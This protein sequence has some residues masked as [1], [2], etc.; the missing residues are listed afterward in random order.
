[1]LALLALGLA[2][3]GC[4]SSAD[5]DRADR[6]GDGDD[7]PS[8]ESLPADLNEL[9]TVA[10]DLAT[11]V[12]GSSARTTV[13]VMVWSDAHR[14]GECDVEG[15]SAV[16]AT[17]RFDATNFPDFEQLLT[18]GLAPPLPEGD[19][20]DEGVVSL[21]PEQ[22]E[23]YLAVLPELDAVQAI[24]SRWVDEEVAPLRSSGEGQRLADGA[25]SCTRERG[26]QEAA[27]VDDFESLL[28]MGVGLESE[29]SDQR[30]LELAEVFVTCT[31]P[32]YDWQ[33]DVLLER[34][35]Q[36]QADHAETLAALS[37]ALADAGYTP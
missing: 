33:R 3:A 22:E 5:L 31:R 37:A 2:I 26:G 20:L 23:C 12:D 30:D 8:A 14:R 19:G 13:E 28:G 11:P 35:P 29:E 1:M 10:L 4:S 36:Y 34:R 27:E 25:V 7:E 17:D 18:E 6:E 9:D 32:Y 24:G 16:S 15:H 21:T